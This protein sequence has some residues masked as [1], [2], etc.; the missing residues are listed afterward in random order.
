MKTYDTVFKNTPSSNIENKCY[1][2][3]LYRTGVFSSDYGIVEVYS[4]KNPNH[5][6]FSMVINGFYLSRSIPRYYT[7]IGLA[8]IANKYAKEMHLKYGR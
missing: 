5:S 1:D 8:R 6:N 2:N 3:N 4:Q 7:K